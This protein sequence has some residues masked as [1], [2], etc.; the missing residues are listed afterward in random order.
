MNK[1][2]KKTWYILLTQTADR[3]ANGQVTAGWNIH[4][5][6]SSRGNMSPS[7]F[8]SFFLFSS[9]TPIIFFFISGQASLMFTTATVVESNRR[10]HRPTGSRTVYV[11]H[12]QARYQTGVS[13]HP[14]PIFN[15]SYVS[16]L[17]FPFF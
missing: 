7:P 12:A 6:K 8:P 3:D 4:S 17:F 15:S 1:C 2:K 16:C 10:S 14:F 9:S 5:K 11:H 13:T